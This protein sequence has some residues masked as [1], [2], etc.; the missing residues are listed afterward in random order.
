MR[1]NRTASSARMASRAWKRPLDRY[2]PYL[3]PQTGF[4]DPTEDTHGSHG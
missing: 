1:A 2:N 3:T 4:P